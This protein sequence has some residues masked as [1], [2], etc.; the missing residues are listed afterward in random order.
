MVH[1]KDH[2]LQLLL[3]FDGLFRHKG[4]EEVISFC[5]KKRK[6][7]KPLHSFKPTPPHTHPRRPKV[8]QTITPEEINI[9]KTKQA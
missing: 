1:V 2:Q 8:K 7:N 9:K 6:I 5:G 3:D 4:E